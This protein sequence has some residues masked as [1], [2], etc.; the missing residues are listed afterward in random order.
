M[1]QICWIWV[2]VKWGQFAACMVL[3]FF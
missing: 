1:K 3:R 2:I